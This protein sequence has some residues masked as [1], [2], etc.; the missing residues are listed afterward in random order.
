MATWSSYQ[1]IAITGSERRCVTF[2]FAQKSW[3]CLTSVWLLNS[4][5]NREKSFY[6]KQLCNASQ[7]S[8]R[9]VAQLENVN[10]WFTYH[11]YSCTSS[12]HEFWIRSVTKSA[13]CYVNGCKWFSVYG[14]PIRTRSQCESNKADVKGSTFRLKLSSAMKFTMKTGMP[15]NKTCEWLDLFFLFLKFCS[16]FL[17]SG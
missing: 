9:C 7:K 16:F 15:V 3:T 2:P 13:T 11:Q 12:K 6:F 14:A 4:A 17:F 8:K 5:A 1:L 10:L